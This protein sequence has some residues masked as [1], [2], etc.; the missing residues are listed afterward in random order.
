MDDRIL[1]KLPSSDPNAIERNDFDQNY[2]VRVQ[3]FW[4]DA[5]IIPLNNKPL[6]SCNHEFIY[7]HTGVICTKCHFGLLGHDLEIQS[8]KL[9][10]HGEP[11]GL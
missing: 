3:D 4:K 10:S 9:F 7:N 1:P 11:I 6:T 8:G 5:E 2:K